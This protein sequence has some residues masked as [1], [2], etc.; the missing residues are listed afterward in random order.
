M[1]YHIKYLISKGA[2]SKCRLSRYN[3]TGKVNFSPECAPL[4]LLQAIS[5]QN[6][7]SS[8]PL[9]T[10]KMTFVNNHTKLG[11]CFSLKTILYSGG[12]RNFKI[13]GE[14]AVPPRN[15][16]WGLKIVLMPLHTYTERNKQ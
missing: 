16:S 4:E 5:K 3:V 11:V 15:N 14:G 10:Y 6:V 8:I 12:S 13:G 9:W 1:T 2:F 7:H